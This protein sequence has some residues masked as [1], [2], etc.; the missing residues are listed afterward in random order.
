MA[1]IEP[2]G[3]HADAERRPAEERQLLERGSGVQISSC[4]YQ[5][6]Q[7]E[8]APQAVHDRGDCGEQFGEEHERRAQARGAELGDEDGNAERDRRGDEQRQDRRVERAPDERERAE[9]AGHRIPGG[10]GPE[11]EAEPVGSTA[12]TRPNSTTPI[13]ATMSSTKT[14]KAPVTTRKPRSPWLARRVG[15]R[16][17]WIRRHES[18][19][20]P[21]FPSS[22]LRAA[23]VRSPSRWRTSA[24]R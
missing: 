19:P 23:A 1:R 8:D 9:I 20:V 22:P 15:A 5:R 12:T 18:S 3:Q 10:R 24:R 7:H 6:H 17:R 16:P 11:S 4:A 14:A 21:P 13:A 2:G